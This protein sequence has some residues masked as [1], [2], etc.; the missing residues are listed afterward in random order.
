MALEQVCD[1]GFVEETVQTQQCREFSSRPPANAPTETEVSESIGNLMAFMPSI[2]DQFMQ[3][4]QL[5]AG[6]LSERVGGNA[7]TADEI[8]SAKNEF[9][10]A[11]L[12]AGSQFMSQRQWLVDE[13]R[14]FDGL[15]QGTVQK[16]IQQTE[17]AIEAE[18]LRIRSMTDDDGVD[19][20]AVMRAITAL[21]E[22][23]SY[24]EGLKFQIKS[25]IE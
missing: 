19:L 2:A 5:A 18:D 15:W 14:S 21:N 1:E 17:A 22:K 9:V 6:K 4:V 8:H 23:K 7:L 11:M 25:N 24:L 12:E 16:K 13:I 20:S 3:S 10:S